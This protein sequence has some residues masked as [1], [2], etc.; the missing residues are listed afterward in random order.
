MLE[1]LRQI[2]SLW[3]KGCVQKGLSTGEGLIY[4]VRDSR[5][6][7]RPEKED[8]KP[9]GDTVEV[10]VDPGVTDKRRIVVETEFSTVLQTMTR[11][12]NVLTGTIRQAWDG[13]TLQTMTR[14]APLRATGTHISMIGHITPA[15]VARYM[16][17]TDM[18]NGFANRMLWVNAE[19]A[20]LLP[21]GGQMPNVS[22]FVQ[23]LHE[24]V[25]E[26]RKGG[27]IR[28]TP[29][30]E[31]VWAAVYPALSTRPP[32]L[33]GA[34]TGRAEAQVL[35]LSLLWALLDGLREIRVSHLLAALACREFAEATVRFLFG[36]RTGDGRMDKILFALRAAEVGLTRT[37][38]S[39]LFGR[40][41]KS[42]T[43]EFALERLAA[44]GLASKETGQT[45]GR[46]EERWFAMPVTT[47]T[48]GRYLQIARKAAGI[49]ETTGDEEEGT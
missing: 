47:S 20:R 5:T 43:I 9:T 39:D 37:Q 14:S 44:G 1:V 45:G 23:T 24:R 26:A 35:R 46:D 34:L 32:G 40:N 8:G 2:D 19:R 48:G 38:I 36:D 6:E 31:V 12:G 22:T 27:L 10:V 16:Q 3:H 13:D 7:E 18:W 28:R 41:E 33:Y 49:A 4:H 42:T 25:V 15:D 21:S 17:E 29:E 11:Q 30:A